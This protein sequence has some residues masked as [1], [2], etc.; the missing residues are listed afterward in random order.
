[1]QILNLASIMAMQPRVLVLDEP[2]S[3]LD[4]VATEKFIQSLKKINEDFGITVILS[5]HRLSYI[6]DKA[7]KLV[8]MD[9]GKIVVCGKPREVAGNIASQELEKLMPIPTRISRKCRKDE[10]ESVP[11][12]IKEGREWLLE[13]AEQDKEIKFCDE[14]NVEDG[15]REKCS[16]CCKNVWFRYEKK[17]RDILQGLDLSVK[18]GEIFAI[19]G[20]NGA[21]K[22]T[23]MWLLSSVKKPYRGK[24]SIDKKVALLPQNVQN[25]FSRD[26]V[27]EELEGVDVAFIRQMGLD[28]L[29]KQHPYDISGGQQQKLA[30][31]KVLKENPEILLLDEP[32]KA[33]DEIYK[34]EL[35]EILTE[36]KRQGKTIIMVSHDLDFCGEYA[37]R[38]GLFANGSLIAVRDSREFFAHNRFYTTTVS[39]MTGGIIKNAVKM[40]DVIWYMNS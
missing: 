15:K 17:E 29:L 2:T 9:G 10:K 8:V 25:L 24:I 39:K 13:K 12:S 5:E 40:E 1:M 3:Q 38:C 19:L 33:I 30:L 32:T 37:D 22:T 27:E 28:N 7:D 26:S 4:P 35:G 20:G 23:M 34:E 6:L 36:L 11:L 14:K 21:G 31:A 16:V 18:E